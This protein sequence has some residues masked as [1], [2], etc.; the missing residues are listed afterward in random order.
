LIQQKLKS[1]G[2]EFVFL[3]PAGTPNKNPE[4]LIGAFGRVCEKAGI[5]GFRFHDLRHT[6]ATGMIERGS[7]IVAV[8][9]VLGHSD[10]KMTMRYS[11]PEDSLKEAVELLTDKF[12]AS[13]TDKSTDI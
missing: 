8:S 13:F 11:H 4:S 3:S 6:A 10:L 1:G 7:S 12:S 2:S 5:V 9:K